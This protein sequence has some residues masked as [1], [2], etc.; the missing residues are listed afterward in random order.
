MGEKGCRDLISEVMK[1]ICEF[2]FPQISPA[3]ESHYML[4]L[5]HCY[6]ETMICSSVGYDILIGEIVN[7]PMEFG[8]YP[9][10]MGHFL[11]RASL[12]TSLVRGKALMSEVETFIRSL[13][14]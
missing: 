13:V 2:R 4:A 6:E 5:S 8:L 1:I 7:D 14:V 9:P 12:S 11:I 10:G 3:G